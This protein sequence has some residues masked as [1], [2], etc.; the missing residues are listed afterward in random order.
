MITK[1]VIS[2][3][4]AFAMICGITYA[5]NITFTEITDFVSVNAETLTLENSLEYELNED[6]TEI[7]ITGCSFSASEI[8][9]PSKIDGVPVTAIQK[10]AFHGHNLTKVTIPNSITTINYE[11][12]LNCGSLES[13][14]LPDSLTSI[15]ENAFRNCNSLTSITLPDSLTSIGNSAFRNCTILPS[16]TIPDSITTIGDNAFEFC[17]SLTE[18]VIPDSVSKI[19]FG[20]FFRC[21]SLKKVTIPDSVTSIGYL[22]FASCDSLTEVTIPDSV[23]NIADKAFGYYNDGK[24]KYET[25]TIYGVKDSAAETYAK[26]NEFEFIEIENSSKKGDIDGDGTITSSDA[27]NVL[28]LV[29]NVKELTDEQKKAADLDG[30]GEITSTDALYILQIIVGLR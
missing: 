12:F 8:E 17:D 28:Q 19:G 2:G 24:D 10:G 3:L 23:T 29:V 13:V 9:I 15:E 21:S 1:K 11:T 26:E 14:I 22:A 30:D 4:I 7:T 6:G 18:V 25:F 5:D 20:V 27:L 16:I